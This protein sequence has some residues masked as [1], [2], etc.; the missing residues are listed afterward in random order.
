M[1]TYNITVNGVTYT[2]EVEEVASAAAAT[3]APQSVA[4]QKPAAPAAPKAAPKA[5][6]G[7]VSVKAPM[8]G[9]IIKVNVKAGDSVK[10]G[11]VLV[12]LEAMKMENDV[13]A[14]EDGVVA[15]VEVAQGATVETDAVLVSLN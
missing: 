8:P 3:T 14:P 15:S 11:D 1:K 12:V 9:N 13:C 4:A 6:A 2:V 5:S 7:A 10:R